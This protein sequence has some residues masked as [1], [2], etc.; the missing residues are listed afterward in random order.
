MTFKEL[1][2]QLCRKQP[3]LEKG[4]AT[5]EITATNL[6]LLLEQAYD[7]GALS[8]KPKKPNPFDPYPFK[9]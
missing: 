4:T 7:Q 6:K 5:I 2:A 8:T 9:T 1:W 3:K